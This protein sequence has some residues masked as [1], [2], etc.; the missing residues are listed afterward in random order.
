MLSI[1]RIKLCSTFAN[2]GMFSIDEYVQVFQRKIT[3]NNLDGLLTP[4]T[5]KI[6]NPPMSAMSTKT[7]LRPSWRFQGPRNLLKQWVSLIPGPSTH[8]QG[9]IQ[10]HQSCVGT[11]LI[12]SVALMECH[13]SGGLGKFLG[14]NT[15]YG[16]PN[17][18]G[19]WA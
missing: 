4:E 13:G 3:Q 6:W 15:S 8:H 1:A 18:Q 2:M 5:P 12:K 14:L 10:T 16:S 7:I 19:I 11:G 17:G 9:S